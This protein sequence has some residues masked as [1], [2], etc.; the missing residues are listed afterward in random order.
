MNPELSLRSDRSHAVVLCCVLW[1]ACTVAKDKPTPSEDAGPTTC[2]THSECASNVC[3]PDASCADAQA[4][5]YVDPKGT[6]NMSCTKE[7]PCSSVQVALGTKRPYVVI[8]GSNTT[9]QTIRITNQNVTLFGSAGAKLIR[10]AP[11]VLIEVAGTSQA[12][13]FDLEI[14]GASG[15][16]PKTTHGI[17]LERGST[18]TVSLERV[19]ISSH[20]GDGLHIDGGMAKVTGST[21]SSNGTGLGIGEGGNATVVLTTIN[22]NNYGVLSSYTS[23]GVTLD[24]SQST[25]SNNSKYGVG[26]FVDTLRLSRS[27]ISGNRGV[28]L[29]FGNTFQVLN[30]YIV[31]NSDKG[32]AAVWM[33]PDP[34]GNSKFEFNTVADNA[35]ELGSTGGMDFFGSDTGIS[36]PNNIFARNTGMDPSSPQVSPR[37]N[38]GNSFVVGPGANMPG[39]VHPDSPPYDYHLTASTPAAILDAAACGAV[40]EDFDGDMRPT[41]GKCDVGADE[42]Q[43]K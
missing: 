8:S 23:K 28:A 21:L 4:V 26:A 30:N 17:S 27:I 24:I 6:D 22:N 42:Y 33:A 15:G 39:F 36:I 20:A 11:G 2:T 3:L 10:S 37:G 25:V 16:D 31:R 18:V 9:A 1:V 34:T 32:S 7:V 19:T 35:S 38:P 13:L 40:A 43:P 41:H 29:A 14:I 5:A 12:A